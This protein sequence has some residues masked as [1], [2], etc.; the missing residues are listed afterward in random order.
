MR[1]TVDH[2]STAARTCTQVSS[3]I[4]LAETDS[5]NA[6]GLR[7]AQDGA[8]DFTVI[9]TA[10]QTAGRGRHDRVWESPEGSSLTFSVLL[11]PSLAPE[12][13]GHL[14]LLTGLAV[15]EGLTAWA[16]ARGVDGT[17]AIGLK[18]P[19]DVLIDGLKVCGV[20]LETHITD[21]KS[22]DLANGL[23][24]GIGINVD[25]RGFDR[26]EAFKDRA[27]SLA[28]W[29]DGDV[30]ASEVMTHVLDALHRLWTT[31]GNDPDACVA[32]VRERC[33]TIGRSVTAHGTD[34]A[35]GTVTGTAIGLT[36]QGH[37]VIMPDTVN[38][39]D[40][41]PVVVRAADVEHLR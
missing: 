26:P 14:P 38:S 13:W 33:I 3:V 41:T 30:D 39:N 37:L 22:M 8:P 27:T 18:W 12:D 4:S 31:V 34:G 10:A 1:S 24:A 19:N 36:P 40:N 5:T 2:L 29:V 28:E 17:D 11:R 15:C 7:A 16:S 6:V 21:G 32:L 25:W 35:H 23:V 9:L 20:L